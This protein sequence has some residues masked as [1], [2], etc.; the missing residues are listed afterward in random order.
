VAAAA[1]AGSGAAPTLLNPFA[2]AADEAT[3]KS[4]L[5]LGGMG[6]APKRKAGAAG[7]G[8]AKKAR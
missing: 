2:R 4:V 5:E 8:G 7:A 6:K 1:P 3:G